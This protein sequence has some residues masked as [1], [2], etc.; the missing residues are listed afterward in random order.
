[1]KLFRCLSAFAVALLVGIGPISAEEPFFMTSQGS[2]LLY[3]T[4]SPGSDMAYQ[5]DSLVSVEGD[6]LNGSA[7][8]AT[9]FY[10]GN[11]QR[12]SAVLTFMKFVNGES[13][14]DW[15]AMFTYMMTEMLEESG[16]EASQEDRDKLDGSVTVKGE[17][18]GIP[19]DIVEGQT[20]PDYKMSVK[21]TFLKTT[22]R[23]FDRKVVSRESIT[24][25]A[26]TFDCFVIEETQDVRN[27]FMKEH[28]R[29][30]TWYARGI[31]AVKVQE[32][33]SDG[34]LITEQELVEKD[35]K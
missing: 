23:G 15:A 20:L 35:I 21:V 10:D 2:S 13:M 33:D 29:S 24:V 27:L 25:P 31:G 1:M 19:N 17:V 28:V 12:Q 6:F 7:R 16:V 26:G 9:V 3:K 18:Y 14:V 22:V 5:R 8:V 30:R 11:M 4:F 32:Y 34:Y